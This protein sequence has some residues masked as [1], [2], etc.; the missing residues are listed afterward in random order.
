M[1]SKINEMDEEVQCDKQTR[2]Y[3]KNELILMCFSKYT[4]LYVQERVLEM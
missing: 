1:G 2:I 4:V 3:G